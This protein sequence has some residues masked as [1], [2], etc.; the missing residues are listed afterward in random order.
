V[1]DVALSLGR[2]LADGRADGGV[3]T[4]KELFEVSATKS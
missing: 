1:N 4:E 2:E 3:V